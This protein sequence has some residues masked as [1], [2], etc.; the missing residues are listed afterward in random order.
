MASP[1]QLSNYTALAKSFAENS[2]RVGA[3][4]LD[5]EHALEMSGEL[6]VASGRYDL[7]TPYSA[8]DWSLA[9][10]DAPAEV[11]ARITATTDYFNRSHMSAIDRDTELRQY[12]QANRDYLV[13]AVRTRLPGVTLLLAGSALAPF[14][15]GGQPHTNMQ[16]YLVLNFIIALTGIYPSRS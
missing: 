5:R 15:G 13:N 14:T 7:G 4:A 2:I 12:L 1:K 10:L 8:T 11:L 16:P 9:Q 6:L 3:I